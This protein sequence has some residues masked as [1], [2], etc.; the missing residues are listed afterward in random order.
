MTPLTIKV[1]S[2]FSFAT[3]GTVIASALGGWDLAMQTLLAVMV[4]D[5]ITGILVA[6]VWKKSGKT[7]SGAADSRAMLKGLCRKFIMICLVW[8][9]QRIDISMGLNGTLRNG[10]VLFFTGNE[11]ISIIENIGI[12]GVPFPAAIK[13]AFEQLRKKGDTQ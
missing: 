6:V 8:I 7:K 13:N 11:G 1:L 10:M 5:M 12:M 3:V 4:I 9:G 2:L